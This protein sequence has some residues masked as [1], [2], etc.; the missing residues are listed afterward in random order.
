MTPPLR[1]FWEVV[2]SFTQEEKKRFLA[3]C[4]GTD[5]API[6]GLGSLE[7]VISRHGEDSER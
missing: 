5:R 3:F 7:F 4:T 2:H 6:E 1:S